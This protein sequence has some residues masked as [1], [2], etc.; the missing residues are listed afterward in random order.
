MVAGHRVLP[1]GDFGSDG[2]MSMSFSQELGRWLSFIVELFESGRGLPLVAVLF[3]AGLFLY[4]LVLGLSLI[5]PV[6][7]R[8]RMPHH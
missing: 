6:W 5:I 4:L 3:V 1:N 2:E 8:S 7:R